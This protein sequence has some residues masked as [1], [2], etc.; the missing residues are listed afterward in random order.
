MSAVPT[1]LLHATNPM[2]QLGFGIWQVPEPQAIVAVAE[3]LRVGY[4]SID[5]A[6]IYGNEGAVPRALSEAEVARSEVF[7]T[8]KLWNSSHG[9][10]A[11][12]RAFDKSLA[13]LQTDYVDLYLI[14][15]PA[16]RRDLYVET[17]K[18][19][20]RLKEEGRARSIGVSNFGPEHLR[21]V[22]D[23]VG[24]APALN[25]IE[26]HPRFAQRELRKVHAELGVVTEAWSPLGQGALLTDPVVLAL[27]E[28]HDR[29]AAQVLLRWHLQH[30]HVVI[31]KSST[32]S[33]IH[34]N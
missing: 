23:E 16:P 3:A 21:R 4:R 15:W 8:T 14:H 1:V 18:A 11:A 34:E 25:Q 19:L 9:F 17:Y 10:D 26:L 24:Q 13:E 20:V 27:A 32:K 31:P 29:T 5:T 22:V 12:L 2:P 28:K 7:V 30:G 6:T 33:R